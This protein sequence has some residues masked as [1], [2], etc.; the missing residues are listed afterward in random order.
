[1]VS[2]KGD[3][4]VYAFNP[5]DGKK[6]WKFA[7]NPKA[8]AFKP[9]GRSDK[10]YIMETPVFH[11]SL[12]FASVATTQTMAQVLGICGALIL[13]NPGLKVRMIVGI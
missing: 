1:M 11:K 4:W 5:E 12:L 13:Q 10:S 2:P 6:F 7:C 3:E 9:G 8:V